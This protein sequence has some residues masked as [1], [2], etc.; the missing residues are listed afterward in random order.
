MARILSAGYGGQT[1]LS[2]ATYGLVRDL[3]HSD[4][5]PAG[6]DMLDLGEHRLKDLTRPEHIFQL[7]IPGLPSRFPPLK[8]LD[9]YP[10]NL[11]VQA[12]PFIGREKEIRAV[13]ALLRQPGT[14]LVTLTG[15][16]GTGKTR[17][18]LQMAAELLEDFN[19]GVWFVELAAVND[20]SLVL[21]AM[22]AVL[23]V[24]EV[25]RGTSCRHSQGLLTRQADVCAA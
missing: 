5:L 18:G 14:S 7:V 13:S 25:L 19:D 20:Y 4:E 11:P 8:T 16:G 6:V 10:N 1:L 3:L 9:A 24:K 23:N 15:P 22:A 17:L 12:T 2:E 21:P